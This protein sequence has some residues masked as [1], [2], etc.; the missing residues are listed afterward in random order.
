MSRTTSLAW[1]ARHE[2][3]LFWRDWLSLMTARKRRREPLLVGVLVIVVAL[4]H[5]LAYFTVALVAEAG[6][7]ADKTTLVTLS[8]IMF[9]SWTLML[10]QAMESVTRAFYV[11]ADLD[12]VL[13]SPASARRV[14][15]VRM[16]AI[17]LAAM[18]LTTVLAGPFINV[19]V[20]QGGPRWLAAYAVLAAM[21]ALATALAIV[22]TAALFR[23]LGPRRTRLISQIL[24]AVIS[25]A[26][27]VGAQAAANI[28]TGSFAR[29]SLFRSESFVAGAPEAASLVWWPARAALGDL[30]ALAVVLAVSLGLLALVITIFSANFGDR[31]IAAA[32]VG[33]QDSRKRRRRAPFRPASIKRALRRKEWAL[34]RRDPWLLSQTL[35]QVLYLLLP[36]LILWHNFGDGVSAFLVLVPILVMGSGQLAGGI[37]WLAV[38]GE[39]APD[40]LASAPVSKHVLMSAKIESVLGAVAIVLSPLLF[41][42]A[43]AAPKLA[44]VAM[45][46]IIVSASSGTMIQIWYRAQAK[47]SALH[48]RQTPSRIATLAEALSSI[49]WAGTAALAAAG[50]WFA[51]GTALA[52]LLALAGTWAIR[53][54]L[55]EGT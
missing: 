54:R 39:D 15:A 13:S 43:I 26:F 38:S 51:T 32:S 40:F 5:V 14:F 17:A 7:E 9:L 37:A 44:I 8:G 18:L 36:A 22:A 21:G 2:L 10:A 29:V 52:A 25:A 55:A 47:R 49:L 12:L 48:R 34:L 20:A 19:L 30:S 41:G 27:V 6:I 28:S 24:S 33:Y 46:G 16:A 4:M 45:L 1:F 3:R 53:P 23:C 11:R 35:M 31:V 50:S 42:L